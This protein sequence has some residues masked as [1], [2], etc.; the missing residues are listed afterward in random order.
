MRGNLKCLFMM[1]GGSMFNHKVKLMRK[2]R[3][4]VCP[5]VAVGKIEMRIKKI[6][7]LGR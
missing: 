6:F 2:T 7:G 5:N 1:W 3:S 4:P